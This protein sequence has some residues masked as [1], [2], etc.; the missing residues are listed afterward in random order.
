MFKM[1]ACYRVANARFLRS[2][3]HTGIQKVEYLESLRTCGGIHCIPR[4]AR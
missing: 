1:Q 2:P 3:R 4:A